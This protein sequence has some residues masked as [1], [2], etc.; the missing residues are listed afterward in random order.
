MVWTKIRLRPTSPKPTYTR[1]DAA[2]LLGEARLGTIEW[3]DAGRL[4]AAI[5]CTGLTCRCPAAR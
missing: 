5:Y 3:F 2:D 1:D 4:R